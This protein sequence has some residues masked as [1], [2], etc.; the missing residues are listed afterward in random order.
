M[1]ADFCKCQRPLCPVSGDDLALWR[2]LAMFFVS[3][4]LPHICFHPWISVHGSY[5]Y[6]PQ[7]SKHC[8]SAMCWHGIM[9]SEVSAISRV[10]AIPSDSVFI[11]V[12]VPYGVA[13]SYYWLV[14]KN[15]AASF[16]CL[17]A[18]YCIYSKSDSVVLKYIPNLFLSV[19]SF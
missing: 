1:Q 16:P 17:H 7:L 13:L 19:L 6:C 2:Y 15:G 11:T 9:Q 14:V 3:F 18:W 5:I 4:C 10:L 12:F 8:W